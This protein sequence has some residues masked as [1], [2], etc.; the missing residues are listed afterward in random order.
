MTWPTAHQWMD[1]VTYTSFISTAL[2]SVLP[3]VETFDKY[4]RFQVGYALALSILKQV[5]F[6]LRNILYKN[7]ST[8]NGAVISPASAASTA[9]PVP[10][11]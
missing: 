10:K 8:Q 7:I 1:Y 2:Y 9:P 4:P 11:I 3:T 6:N 5:G